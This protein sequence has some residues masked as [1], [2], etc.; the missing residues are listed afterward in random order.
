MSFTAIDPVA[1]GVAATTAATE[2]AAPPALNPQGAVARVAELRQL[3]AQAQTGATASNGGA[4]F[5]AALASAASPPAALTATSPYG[6]AGSNV[7]AAPSGSASAPYDGLVTAAAQRHGIDPALLHGL[8]QQESGFDPS[9]TSSAGALGLCQL[10]PGTAASLGVTNPLDPAQS[11]DGGARYLRQQ[12]DAFGGD[13]T[14]ALAA[15]NAG[16]GAVRRYGGVPPY[17]ETQA[18]VQKVTGYADA[19]RATHGATTVGALPPGAA[20]A[21]VLPPPAALPPTSPPYSIT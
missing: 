15:Y 19:Y 3:I 16:P 1:A 6:I 14:L 13:P 9:A 12:L 7:T 20:P 10:M 21:S 8:I 4:S 11:I 18:Y 5:P 2:I 17:A